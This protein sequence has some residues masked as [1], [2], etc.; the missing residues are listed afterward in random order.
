MNISTN[1][2]TQE[3]CR[4]IESESELEE[5]TGR[6]NGSTGVKYEDN[7]GTNEM[8]QVILIRLK[9]IVSITINT[10][11][12]TIT[13]EGGG[14]LGS[15]SEE[16]TGS[17]DG[18]KGVKCE[19]NAGTNEMLQVGLI[20]LQSIASVAINIYI[21]YTDIK[22]QESETSDLGLESESNGFNGLGMVKTEYSTA[23]YE[24]PVRF[25]K[26]FQICSKFGYITI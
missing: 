10:I 11:T 12:D 17:V 3:G 6:V 22:T 23:T 7:A 1:I 14:N 24:M 5:H 19:D 8:L 18:S 15:E 13:Q 2:M 21:F 20:R 4:N 9:L 26:V 25:M 16:H